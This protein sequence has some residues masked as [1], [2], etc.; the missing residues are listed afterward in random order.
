MIGKATAMRTDFT[1]FPTLH[2]E[3]LVLRQ[4]QPG[5]APANFLLRTDEQAMAYIGRARPRTVDE[6]AATLHLLEQ[7]RLAGQRI[8]WIITLGDTLGMIGSIG[9][10]KLKP[11]H[12]CAEVGFQLT[13]A[14]WGHGLMQEALNAVVEYAFTHLGAHRVEAMTDPRNART[15][16]LLERCGFA[17]EG[18]LRESYYWDGAFLGTAV[19]GRLE[20]KAGL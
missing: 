14:H 17:L 20:G 16:S 6:A 8:G 9:L 3:R 10:Y 15:R 5:D 19:Y 13:P 11:E 4:P 12:H 1:P 18:T 7:D 2:T